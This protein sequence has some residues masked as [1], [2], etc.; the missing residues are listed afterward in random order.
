MYSCRRGARV[1][2]ESSFSAV[3]G[4]LLCGNTLRVAAKR[5]WHRT[6]NC[7]GVMDVT[8]NCGEPTL[9]FSF[10][11]GNA[12]IRTRNTRGV[13]PSRKARIIAFRE[14]QPPV[15]RIRRRRDSCCKSPRADDSPATRHEQRLSAAIRI[16]FEQLLSERS[17]GASCRL[18]ARA[19][20]VPGEL[21]RHFF[22][23]KY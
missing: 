20:R 7:P 17:I 8:L 5:R 11:G 1:A 19:S 13:Y 4:A 22:P 9:Y 2:D 18:I 10:D 3:P 12:S 23:K 21:A 6:C 14:G 16:L 15:E